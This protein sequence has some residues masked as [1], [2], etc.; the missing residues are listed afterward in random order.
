MKDCGNCPDGDFKDDVAITHSSWQWNNG[1]SGYSGDKAARARKAVATMGYKFFLKQVSLSPQGSTV[2]IEAKV[3]NRGVAPFY[4]PVS[5]Q[6]EVGGTTTTLG[7]LKALLPNATA[8]LSAQLDASGD[9]AFLSLR[10]PWAPSGVR[11][12]IA[13]QQVERDGVIGVALDL[14]SASN[15]HLEVTV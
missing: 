5:L 15:H 10:S 13:E 4:Y 8:D 1:L 14:P 12:A 6:V 2:K 11:F 7:S 3:E 9:T